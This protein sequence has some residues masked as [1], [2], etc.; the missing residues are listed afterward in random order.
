MPLR[1]SA[2]SWGVPNGVNVRSTCPGEHVDLAHR[3][4]V[5]AAH[6]EQPAARM[7][8][9]AVRRGADVDGPDDGQ[10]RDI[11]G[12]HRRGR[13]RHEELRAVGRDAAAPEGT[14][15]STEPVT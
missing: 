7:H 5:E 4:R 10:G 14:A 2:I 9:E 15:M 6:V 3:A 1:L 11:H 13:R 8:R 12:H